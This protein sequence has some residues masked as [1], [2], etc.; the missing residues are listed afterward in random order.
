[1]IVLDTNVVSELSKP[2]PHPAVV[3]WL[4]AQREPVIAAPSLAG[5]RLGVARLPEGRR[6]AAL[7]DAI[8]RFVTDD[9]AGLVLAFDWACADAYGPIVAARERAGRPIAVTDAQIAAICAVH[10]AVLA[11]RNCVTS[12][13]PGSRWSTPGS[14]HPLPAELP[15]E[16]RPRP[17]GSGAGR[18]QTSAPMSA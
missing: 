18:R 10:D 17:S 2:A 1:M 14:R 16:Q 13:T 9:L 7:S 11:T 8:D 3:A 15:P 6:K 4:D 5:L 12:R